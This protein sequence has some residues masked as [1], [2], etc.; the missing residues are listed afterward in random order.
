M[1]ALF[2]LLPF[3]VFA[4]SDK[5]DTPTPDTTN[6]QAAQDPRLPKLYGYN[7]KNTYP[8][9][10]GAYT[11]G[12]L[13]DEG[14]LYESTGRPRE[15]GLRKVKLET[16]EVVQ[17]TRLPGEEF[18]EGLARYKGV[19]LQLTWKAGKCVAWD[20]KTLSELYRLDYPGE[21]WGLTLAGEELLMT[22]GTSR[23]QV[24]NPETFE[25]IR[26]IDV[27][28]FN[29]QQDR[30]VPVS[31]LNE[32]EWI[33]GELWANI[34]QYEMIV[35]IDIKTGHVTS[36]IDFS[37]LTSRQGVKDPRQDVLNGIAWDKDTGRI[38]ITGKY[39]PNLYEIELVERN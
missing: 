6:G 9:D 3:L 31:G 15:S 21:G 30:Y 19:F 8:H 7:I 36:V 24:R 22:S 18:G 11:Q 34:Y 16:G 32:L 33:D 12:L 10:T 13:W 17:E 20:A 27:T 28:T 4:C 1:R 35:R 38:F 23:I 25:L 29:V 39:W 14:F 37:G 26:N 5:K 2:L